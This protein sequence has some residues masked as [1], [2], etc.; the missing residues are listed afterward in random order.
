MKNWTAF[1]LF[2]LITPFISWGVEELLGFFNQNYLW[3]M[4]DRALRWSYIVI[5]CAIGVP[6]A[7]YLSGK[8]QQFRK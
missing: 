8:I 7:N 3:N 2:I 6:L 5:S 1:I 4:S